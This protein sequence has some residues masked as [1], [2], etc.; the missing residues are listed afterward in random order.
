MA[1]CEN[2]RRFGAGKTGTYDRNSIGMMHDASGQ[3]G[4]FAA[5]FSVSEAC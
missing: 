3:E 4:C 5:P 2:K 1:R